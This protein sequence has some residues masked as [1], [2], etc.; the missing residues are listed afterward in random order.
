VCG[1]TWTQVERATKHFAGLTFA[2]LELWRW[3]ARPAALTFITTV[4]VGTE[5]ARLIA[6]SRT[7]SDGS[8]VP[9]S[10]ASQSEP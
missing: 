4:L 6:G 7:S 8:T 2:G 5:A 1:L 10:P 3:G 9:P